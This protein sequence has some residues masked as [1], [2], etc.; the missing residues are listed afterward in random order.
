MPN[1]L[2][3]PPSRTSRM[4]LASLA[5][6]L[7]VSCG[8]GGGS[9]PPASTAGAQRAEPRMS[10]P[11]WPA[12]TERLVRPLRSGVAGQAVAGWQFDTSDRTA[13]Q[14]FYRTLY[15][16]SD[17]IPIAWTGNI[18]RCDAGDTPSDLKDGV[19]RRI[20]WMRAMAGVPA[21]VT[22]DANYNRQAQQAALIMAANGQLSHAPPSNWTCWSSDG[23]LAAGKSNLTQSAGAQAIDNY[24]E[25]FGANNAAVGHRRWLLYP[26]TRFMGSGD[27]STVQDGRTVQANAL[28]VFDDNLRAAR[29]A[30]RSEF[31]AWPPAGHVPHTTVYPRWSFSYPD[32]DFSQASLSMTED[33]KALA[34][35]TEV[36][37]PSY[38]ENTLV[39]FPGSYRDGMRWERPGAD[40]RY[41]VNLRNVRINGLL[42]DFSYTVTVFD[43]LAA[44]GWGGAQSL[45]GN[46]SAQTGQLGNYRFQPVSGATAYQWRASALA[47]LSLFE[48]AEQG[49][50]AMLLATSAGYDPLAAGV[51]AS[52]SRALHLAHVLPT[53]Q[54]MTLRT[55]IVPQSGSVLRFASR[56]GFAT[57]AQTALVELS[58]DEGRS[59]TTLY[60]QAGDGT[61]G[62]T[63]F[64]SRQLPL[65]EWVGRSVLLRLR[66]AFEQGS[67][68]SQASDGVGWYVD[69]IQVLGAAT[70]VA[71][72]T[73]EQTGST[74]HNLSLPSSG[75]WLVQARPGVFGHWADWSS[76]IV[77]AATAPPTR[78]DCLLNWAER[79]Y[80]E[81]LTPPAASQTSAPYRYRAYN[82]AVYVGI[83]SIDAH[84]YY[85]NNGRLEDLG[86]QE[87]WMAQAGC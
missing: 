69:D 6:A 8:G 34:T 57:S 59:W 79:R 75:S 1:I 35:L 16:S 65:T 86:P 82:H 23:A 53:D 70:L 22:L 7:L 80:P 45:S 49:A 40:K 60:R 11:Q 5:G 26:Q 67:Y 39:W 10:A 71:A 66:Y 13:V 81:L 27:V 25:E 85:L 76:G 84:V 21:A 18:G 9:P 42:R 38:G 83:S 29:P 2:R 24:M 36:L 12:A 14:F 78:T 68:F 56:L 46:T 48:G 30:V 3:L 43:A 31:V 41:E 62:E 28:W 19:T 4:L 52:G 47:P 20:N 73:P 55:T 50:G 37:A 72:G 61:R 17:A 51:S 15:A 33:G 77:V 44:P 64:V 63:G 74:S 54:S 32:A 58:A 87:H